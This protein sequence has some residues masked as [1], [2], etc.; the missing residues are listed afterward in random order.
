M[1]RDL[2]GCAIGAL[3]PEPVRNVLR[4]AVAEYRGGR[5]GE[6]KSASPHLRKKVL[7]EKVA[8]QLQTMAA[9]AEARA[10]VEAL[11]AEVVALRSLLL[12]GDGTTR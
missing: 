9:E 11:R 3:C 8:V 10:E 1:S 7:H 12:D 5:R 2:R 4:Q 6:Q